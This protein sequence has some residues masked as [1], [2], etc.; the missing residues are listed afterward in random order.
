MQLLSELGTWTIVVP[1][2]LAL[3]AL[4]FVSSGDRSGQSASTQRP[5]EPEKRHRPGWLARRRARRGVGPG[6]GRWT[7]GFANPV[8]PV[9]VQLAELRHHTLVCGATG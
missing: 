3:V 1:I 7:L 4:R 8:R 6:S 5:E 9:T 2:L